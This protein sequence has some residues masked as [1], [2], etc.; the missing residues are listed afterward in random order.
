MKKRLLKDLPFGNL[1]KGDVL[2]H[3]NSGYHKRFFDTFYS[4]GGS[5]SAG[6]NVFEK[7]EEEI[8]DTIWENEEWFTEAVI[9]HV[10]IVPSYNSVTIRFE[11]LDAEDVTA[12]AKGIEHILPEL[13]KG[14]YTWNIFKDL[15]TSFRNN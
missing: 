8:L 9:N 14:S 2:A 4:T 5:S 15:T 3:Y 7:S 13:S 12:F 11:T 10:E 6:V 1:K